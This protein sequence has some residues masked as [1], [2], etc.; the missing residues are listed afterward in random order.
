[1]GQEMD[2]EPTAAGPWD[3]RICEGCHTH[4]QVFHLVSIRPLSLPLHSDDTFPLKKAVS[5]VFADTTRHSFPGFPS[6]LIISTEIDGL[7]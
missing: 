1:M 7:I 5:Y 2:P 6:T 3:Q 4:D